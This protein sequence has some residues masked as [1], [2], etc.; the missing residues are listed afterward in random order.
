MDWVFLGL[1]LVLFGGAHGAVTGLAAASQKR[2]GD[3][4]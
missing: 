4:Q 3:R 2:E 1:S